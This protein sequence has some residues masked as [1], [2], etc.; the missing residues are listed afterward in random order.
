MAKKEKKISWKRLLVKASED[1]IKKAVELTV[2][3]LILGTAV[4]VILV[5]VPAISLGSILAKLFKL[6]CLE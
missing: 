4:K 3:A 2:L 6:V 5:A 1:A